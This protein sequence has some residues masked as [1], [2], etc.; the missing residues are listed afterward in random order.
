VPA[1]P[2]DAEMVPSWLSLM[3]VALAWAPPLVLVHELG[4]AFA[5][6]ALTDGEVKIRMRPGYAVL[7]WGECTYE[8]DSIR[9]PRAEALIAAAGPAVSLVTA[10][11]LG[12]PALEAASAT[13]QPGFAHQAL[14]VGALCAAGQLLI[15]ALPLQYGAGLG[16]P[17]SESDGRAV[18][19]I[20]TGGPPGGLAREER[21]LRRP[22]RAIGPVFGAVL[23]A[24][25]ALAAYV[26]PMTAV[27]L[28]AIFGIAFLM[29]RNDM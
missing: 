22:R 20:L 10:V 5:A 17:G 18:W 3:L 9:T 21:R 27:L 15:T 16:A 29:Q 24:I 19:R 26:A 23:A 28:V 25:V 14:G 4:H 2:V 13:D 1:E 7:L 6:L 8:P 12:W 11:A